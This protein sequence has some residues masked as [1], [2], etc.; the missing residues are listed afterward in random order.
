[1][2]ATSVLPTSLRRHPYAAAVFVGCVAAAVVSGVYGAVFALVSGT[3]HLPVWLAGFDI[4]VAGACLAIAWVVAARRVTTSRSLETVAATVLTLVYATPL[5]AIVAF[6]DRVE[7]LTTRCCLV[8][9]AAGVVIRSRRSLLALTA[10]AVVT[11]SVVVTVVGPPHFSAQQWWSTW[12]IAAAVCVAANLVARTE[13]G[14]EEGVRR[15]AQS[16][17][18]RDAMTGLPNR[19]GFNEQAE[20]LLEMA[21]RRG[22]PIWCAFA[23][24]DHFKSV[25]DL[26]G[27]DAGDA[28]LVGV[29]AAIRVVARGSDVA[30]R[31][32]GDEFVLLGIGKPPTVRDLERRIADRLPEFDAE[33]LRV[34][35]PSVTVGVAGGSA[36]GDP[37]AGLIDAADALMYERRRAL[38]L[39]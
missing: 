8:L 1:M 18:W 10:G 11:W 31:W 12:L 20:Q 32:G 17:S 21:R 34:W 5:A 37:L 33:L 7:L 19:V 36:Q 25:N 4:V 38:R 3:E 13:R 9:V 23:D 39:Q 16:S 27:H 28:V 24:V 2:S 6:P 15:A 14:L 26:V 35:T 30:C 22:E 29:A